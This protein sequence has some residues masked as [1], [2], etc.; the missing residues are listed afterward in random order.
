MKKVLLLLFFIVSQS[1]FAQ[2]IVGNT[3]VL[4][5]TDSVQSK[6]LNE[7]RTIWVHLPAGAANKN[8]TPRY[9]VVYVLDGS[10]HFASVAGIIQYLSEANGNMFCPDMIVVGI[11]N[12]DRTRDLTPTYGAFDYENK[13]TNSFK[14]SG[15]GEKFT[16]FI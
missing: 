13:P 14:T 5:H 1:A 15:G 7:K 8:N 2:D 3:I 9:P 6:I 10:E 11:N 12:T 16:A 4:G